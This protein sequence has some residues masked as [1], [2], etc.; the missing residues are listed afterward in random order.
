MLNY[1]KTKT[2]IH[3][4]HIKTTKNKTKKSNHTNLPIPISH[5]KNYFHKI[6]T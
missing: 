2:K 3:L 6:Q 4:I 1:N 5:L